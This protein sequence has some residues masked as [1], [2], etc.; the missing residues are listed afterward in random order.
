MERIEYGFDY[1]LSNGLVMDEK[2]NLELDVTTPEKEK[3]MSLMREGKDTKR[4]M[5]RSLN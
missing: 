4:T 5:K 1:W 2:N 3:I